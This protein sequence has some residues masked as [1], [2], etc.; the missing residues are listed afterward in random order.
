MQQLKTAEKQVPVTSASAL[1][2]PVIDVC[3]RI[4]DKKC[5][6]ENSFTEI[7]ENS[8]MNFGSRDMDGNKAK[9]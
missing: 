1:T 3:S 2:L 6:V 7:T 9:V 5:Y 8:E 4:Q